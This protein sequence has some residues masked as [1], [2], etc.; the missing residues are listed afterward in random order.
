MTLIATKRDNNRGG[1]TSQ[2]IFDPAEQGP[3]SFECDDFRSVDEV[4]GSRERSIVFWMSMCEGSL[5]LTIRASN[6][7]C[8][9]RRM[10]NQRSYSRSDPY[11][12][13]TEGSIEFPRHEDISPLFN[14]DELE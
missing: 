1:V 3:L 14:S 9:I 10:F 13:S 8:L 7:M 2:W 12:Y 6:H 4:R 11:Q 5:T